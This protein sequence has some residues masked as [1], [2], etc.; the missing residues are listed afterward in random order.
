MVLLKLKCPYR[1]FAKTLSLPVA[2]KRF[3]DLDRESLVRYLV[4]EGLREPTAD[5]R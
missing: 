2:D 1:R 3:P 4:F 5:L